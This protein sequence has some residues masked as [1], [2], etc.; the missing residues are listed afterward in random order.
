[1]IGKRVSAALFDDDVDTGAGGDIH[2]DIA[3]SRRRTVTQGAVYIERADIKYPRRT[4]ADI[5]LEERLA[6]R[7]RGV[8]HAFAARQSATN[9]AAA[10]GKG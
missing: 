3:A 5:G 10:P 7:S 8:V 2:P 4:L 6:E 9:L 1:M